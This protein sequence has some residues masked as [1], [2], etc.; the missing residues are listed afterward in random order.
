M[1][2]FCPKC[3][4]MLRKG[5]CKCGSKKPTGFYKSPNS[6][7]KHIWNPPSANVIYCKL[8]NISYDKLKNLISRGKY[9]EELTVIKKKLSS[10]KYTCCQCMYYNEVK[11]HCQIKN[12]NFEKNSICKGFEPSKI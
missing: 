10:N 7:V 12:R 11:Y 9:P 2:D 5:P 1:V 3:G 6:L 8:F 4:S